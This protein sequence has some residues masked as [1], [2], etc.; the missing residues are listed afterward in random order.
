MRLSHQR[1]TKPAT[2]AGQIRVLWPET[3]AVNRG[4]TKLGVYPAVARRAGRDSRNGGA[5]EVCTDF[6]QQS[7]CVQRI[8][9]WN[10]REIHTVG[11]VQLVWL[12]WTT[13][14]LGQ[15]YHLTQT[16]ANRY[17]ARLPPIGLTGLFN[18]GL[19]LGGFGVE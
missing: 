10:L 14:Y 3:S 6:C 5:C 19:L 9:A 13:I 16:E 7:L 2:K 15:Q 4:W 11:A 18:G 12:N 8:N 1:A 17:F